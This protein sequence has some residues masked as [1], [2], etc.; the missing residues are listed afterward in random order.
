MDPATAAVMILLSCKPS[1]PFVCKPIGTP[2]AV[3]SS[4][5]QCRT[6]LKQRLA[7]GPS[8]EIIGRCRRNRR[9][10][11]WLAPNRLLKSYCHPRHRE[12]RRQQ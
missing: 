10:G 9:D 12:Q 3:Y 4:L 11:D 1:E 6:S 7:S 2:Q 8:G 5:D